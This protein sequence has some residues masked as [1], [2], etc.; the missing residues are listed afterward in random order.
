MDILSPIWN[1]NWNKVRE[2]LQQL[3]LVKKKAIIGSKEYKRVCN[4]CGIFDAEAAYKD[5]DYVVIAAP[6]NYDSKKNF[7]DTSAV[8]AE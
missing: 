3:Y 2:K 4:K 5:A 8:E 6:T 7:F 1:Y